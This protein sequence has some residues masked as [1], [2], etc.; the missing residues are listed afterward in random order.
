[1]QVILREDVPQ[2]GRSGDMVKVREGF[3]RNYLIPQGLAVLADKQNRRQAEH[4]KRVIEA[5][6]RKVSADA[7]V[8]KEKVEALAINIAKA[9]GEEGKLFG[10]VT[11][12]E[13]AEVIATHGIQIDRKAITLAEPIKSVGV[14]QAT[15][16][17]AP[18]V[19]AELKI[20]VVEQ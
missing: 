17:L 18:S 10:S 6:Q 11:T 16:R 12:R 19:T 13:I 7:A 15:V 1:M 4:H 20:W 5:R 2:L 14:H 9:V 8:L 3:G